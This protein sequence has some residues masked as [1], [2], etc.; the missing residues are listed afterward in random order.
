MLPYWSL[1]LRWLG[2]SASDIG[3]V[4]A[5]LMVTR[6][7]APNLW[8]WLADHH[9]SRLSLIRWGSFGALLAFSGLL[10]SQALVFMLG[11]VFVFRF[12]ECGA[13]AI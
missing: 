8:G 7:G 11:L 4:A 6:M 12:L 2:Y 1:Y 5:V 10:V 13:G 3:W 9:Y